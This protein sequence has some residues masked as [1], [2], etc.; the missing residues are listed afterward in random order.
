MLSC[1]KRSRKTRDGHKIATI[2]LHCINLKSIRHNKTTRWVLW[3]WCVL[4]VFWLCFRKHI[5]F[6]FL[7]EKKREKKKRRKKQHTNTQGQSF[8]VLAFTF[9]YKIYIIKANPSNFSTLCV[10]VNHFERFFLFSLQSSVFVWNDAKQY[11]ETNT[12]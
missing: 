2:N 5:F 3:V 11:K 8:S 1:C 6:L 4:Y 7:C 12:K 10:N 9:S